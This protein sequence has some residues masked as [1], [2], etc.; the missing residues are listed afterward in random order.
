MILIPDH[1][2]SPLCRLPVLSLPISLSSFPPVLYY[3]CS[4]TILSLSVGSL[5]SCFL[6]SHVVVGVLFFLSQKSSST[7]QFTLLAIKTRV[8]D[9]LVGGFSASQ[10]PVLPQL[11][12]FPPVI[13]SNL[14]S[15]DVIFK[16]TWAE[17]MQKGF[18]F[19]WNSP[20]LIQMCPFFLL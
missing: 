10:V 9:C 20:F 6:F 17:V 16:A 7:F 19:L 11:S 1:L 8:S 18:T 12:S 3:K 13:W 5:L 4:L 14:L 15:R 2:F